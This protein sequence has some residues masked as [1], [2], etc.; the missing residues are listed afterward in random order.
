MSVTDVLVHF[1]YAF[2]WPWVSCWGLCWV[3]GVE[4]ASPF[5]PE[6]K[7]EKIVHA[8]CAIVVACRDGFD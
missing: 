7:S 2:S 3:C 8:Y 4:H 6:G 1:A 5:G